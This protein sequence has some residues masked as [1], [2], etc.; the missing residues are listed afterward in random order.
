M[1]D[2][3]GR[4]EFAIVALEGR[5]NTWAIW[6]CSHTDIL[7]LPFWSVITT[8]LYFILLISKQLANSILLT[9]MFNFDD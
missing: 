4:Y 2:Y 7:E 6:P 9:M 1:I 5:N 8:S 3:A